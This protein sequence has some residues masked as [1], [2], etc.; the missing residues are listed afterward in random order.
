MGGEPATHPH[1]FEILKMF[2]SYNKERG[3]EFELAF[4]TNGFGEKAKGIL[5][6]IP[7]GVLIN[8]SNKK[9]V[10]QEHFYSFN[11]APIDL[12]EFKNTDYSNKCAVTRYCGLGL[13]KYGYYICSNASGIDRVFGFDVG[14]K[15]LPNV[16]DQMTDQALLL[17]KYCGRFKK[18]FNYAKQERIS[19]SWEK[20]YEKYKKQR[21][22]LRE[23]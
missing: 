3:D 4:I 23:Y 19:S 18:G 12:K 5:S 16:D 13:N 17:C 7:Q 14:R 20:I 11:V 1:V 8:N 21:P 9:S 15:E 2:I 6:K 10:I 22:Y